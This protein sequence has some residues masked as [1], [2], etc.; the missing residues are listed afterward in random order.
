MMEKRQRQYMND[1][2]LQIIKKKSGSE[3]ANT[4]KKYAELEKLEHRKLA[5]QGMELMR[6]SSIDESMGAGQ[7]G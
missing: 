1:L 3:N 2:K 7:G 5:R 6:P 4:L